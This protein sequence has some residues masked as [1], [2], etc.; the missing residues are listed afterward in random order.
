MFRFKLMKTIQAV[1]VLFRE[2]HTGRMPYI[3]LLK[4]LYLADRASLRETGHPITGDHVVAMDNGPVLSKVY[5]LI[6]GEAVGTDVWNQF[7]RTSHY[8]IE[9]IKELDVGELSRFEVET[10]R[11]VAREREN[12]D[13]WQVVEQTHLFPEWVKNQPATGSS[14]PIPFADILEAVGR[15]GDLESIVRSEKDAEVYDRIFGE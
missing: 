12:D 8:S 4:L 7:F 5:N 11:S 14:R 15:T 10:L 6:K 13:D 1:G 3:R 2:E 9:Q